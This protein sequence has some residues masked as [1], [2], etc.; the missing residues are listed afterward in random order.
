[1]NLALSNRLSFRLWDWNLTLTQGLL[2]KNAVPTTHNLSGMLNKIWFKYNSGQEPQ[3][4]LLNYSSIAKVTSHDMF[5]QAFFKINKIKW[6]KKKNLIPVVY[7]EEE[8]TGW[9]KTDTAKDY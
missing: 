8:N 7:M 1:M 9:A 2:N 5:Q 3:S 4:Y 6:R